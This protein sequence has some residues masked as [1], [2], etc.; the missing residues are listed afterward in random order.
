MPYLSSSRSRVSQTSVIR[1]ADPASREN[2]R[3]CNP[4]SSSIAKHI[5]P[6]AVNRSPWRSLFR[7]MVMFSMINSYP[8]GNVYITIE[9][10]DLFDD[11]M[12]TWEMFTYGKIHHAMNGKINELNDHFQ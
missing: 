1:R 12:T 11:Y 10:V 3:I 5:L 8:L 4:R 7:D 9:M 2:R 6:G